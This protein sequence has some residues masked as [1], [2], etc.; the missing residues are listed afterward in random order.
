MERSLEPS[1]TFVA[2][3]L[4]MRLT[5][6]V[7][8]DN[9]ALFE[10]CA[11]NR[12]LHIERTPAGD[13][14]IMPPTG[15]ESGRRNADLLTD[16][17]IWARRDGTG[18]TFDSSTG[19]LLPDGAERSMDAAWVSASRWNTL[20]PDQRR[21]FPPLCPDFVAELCSPSDRIETLHEK[22]REYIANGAGL[23]WLID[24]DAKVAWVYRPGGAV[25]R[26][27]APETLSGEPVLPGFTL[28]TSIFW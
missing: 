27:D 3:N 10:L 9:D 18:L 2:P 13:L 24:P 12:D 8:L 6:L 17:N 23:G 15:G 16:L 14:V 21:T 19:F 28:S 11:R 5:P 7:P 4:P 26:H 25:E 20:T 22:M 1:M